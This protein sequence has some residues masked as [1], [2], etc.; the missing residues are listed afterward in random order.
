MEWPNKPNREA[1]EIAGFI[2]AYA[3]FPERQRFEV[4]SKQEAPDYVVRDQNSGQEYGVELT[5][6]YLD[7]RSV[8]DVHMKEVAGVTDITYDKDA[9]EQYTRR[10][11]AAVT[12]KV[13][14]AKRGYDS[15]RPLILSIYLNEYISTYF[16]KEQ[17]EAFV[18]RYE[19]VFDEVSPF[20]EV[21]FWN[22][23][24]GGVFRVRPEQGASGRA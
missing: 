23:G 8:P 2:E 16:G 12:E 1:L 11:V 13:C 7:D 14:K 18:S 5:S 20:S 3:R 10:L 21:V 24:N 4:V 22:L 6:V 17:L 15:Q 9:I 19:G